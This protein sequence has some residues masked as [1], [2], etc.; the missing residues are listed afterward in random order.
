MR[1]LYDPVRVYRAPVVEIRREIFEGRE[2]YSGAESYA[3]SARRGEGAG[4]GYKRAEMP[5]MEYG[6]GGGGQATMA[7]LGLS[8]PI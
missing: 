6:G 7:S 5:R 8:K 2:T 4:G 1:S 3:L